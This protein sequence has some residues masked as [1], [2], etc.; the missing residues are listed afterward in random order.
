V[1][2]EG[3]LFVDNG[4]TGGGERSTAEAVLTATLSNHTLQETLVVPDLF[5]R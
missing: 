2:G 5:D 1:T 4:A 3:N